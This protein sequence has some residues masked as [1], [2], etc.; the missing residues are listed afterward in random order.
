[1]G[2]Q[3]NFVAGQHKLSGIILKGII[4]TVG[5]IIKEKLPQ[6]I[7]ETIKSHIAEFEKAVNDPRNGVTIVVEFKISLHKEKLKLKLKH[8]LESMQL[9]VLPGFIQKTK[10]HIKH[11][12]N[13]SRKP[14]IG[15]MAQPGNGSIIKVQQPSVN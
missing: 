5:K 2:F 3:K 9:A 14:M 4:D 6:Q 10:P 8:G 7:I 1:M 12:I 13:C 15:A 11:H